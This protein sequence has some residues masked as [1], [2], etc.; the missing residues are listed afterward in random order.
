MI[1]F[2]LWYLTLSLLGLLAFPLTYRLFP[3]LADRGYAL[4]RTL[5]LLI[6]GYVFWLLA[7]L[8]V[9]QNDAGGILFAL[10]VLVGLSAWALQADRARGTTDGGLSSIVDSLRSVIEW[11]RSNLRTVLTVEILFLLTLALL[12]VVRAANPETVG[13]EKPMEMAFINAILH[14]P[15]FPP[16]DPWL[17]GYAISYY[18]FGYVMA[19]MV[20]KFTST[21]GGVAF[22]LMLSL[23]FALSAV[24]AYGIIHNLLAVYH[25]SHD[26]ENE[27]DK[28]RI[29][30][31]WGLFGPLFL[32]V[33]SNVEGFLEVLHKQGVFWTSDQPSTFNFWLWLDDLGRRISPVIS[34]PSDLQSPPYNFWTWLN[35][36]ELSQQPAPLPGG[37]IARLS[38]WLQ[39]NSIGLPDRLNSW[40]K[41]QF[42]PDRFWWWWRA[43]R[44]L[45]DYDLTGNWREIIDEFPM[46]SYILGDL[47]PHVLAMPFCM[48]S[49]AIALNLYL[50]GWRGESKMFGLRLYIHREGLVLGA[51]VFGGLAFLNTWDSPIHLAVF[52]GA[53]VLMLAHER[54]WGWERV[55]DFFILGVPLVVGA[56]VLYLPFYAGFSSQAGGIV[57]NLVWPTRGAYLWVMF[58]TLLVPLF[59]YL[60]Y[61]WRSES[62]SVAWRK[63]LLIAFGIILIMWSFSWLLAWLVVAFN[64]D[65]ADVFLLDQ[66]ISDIAVL[67]MQAA[68]KR[69]SD[70]AGLLT[71]FL[72][73]AG[74]LAVFLGWK[75]GEVKIEDSVEESNKPPGFRSSFFVLLLVLIGALLV[76]APEFVYLR[77][78][79]GWRMNTIFKFYYQSWQLWSLAAAF[80]VAVLLRNLRG[81]A[82]AAYAFAA[83]L[84]IGAGLTYP[85]L[86]IPNKTNYFAPQTWTLDGA[87]FLSRYYPDDAVAIDWLQIAPSGVVAEAVG[88]SYTDYARVATYSGQPNVL[89]WPG[90]ESQWRGGGVE[91]G[92]RMQD[93]ER[94]YTTSSWDEAL[95]IMKQYDIHYVFVGT[96]ERDTYRL[97][98]S[99]FQKNM[100]EVF[101]QG[102]VVIY[103]LP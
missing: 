7:S 51:L 72:L 90:H 18:Y 84:V 102:N 87:E 65:I 42:M 88:G 89:G 10:A 85:A 83:I 86:G 49:L 41:E 20:A 8:G 36:K 48:L 98:E 43:S 101:H 63:G 75:Y 24:G 23:T 69:L 5:G 58:G 35:M 79:F 50:G 96:L 91:M 30:P 39:Q 14:S 38:F 61:V 77:D 47:H 57:P 93:I 78:Q 56:I 9:V 76:L 97:D 53:Y 71:I 52:C 94:L 67:F 46:F 12:A 11:L 100:Q 6:W 55:E 80:G 62:V 16:H 13:T 15:T 33:V 19:A 34:R 31:V 82:R 29:N 70:G 74:T 27:E 17:S 21:P 73:L 28:Q 103:T 44:V 4:A 37:M 3:A 64:P 1:Y 22:N 45:Q 2:L 92:T 40:F 25:M 59:L 99:K 68:A 60:I 95:A 66:G 54:G 32:L 81:F 26:E